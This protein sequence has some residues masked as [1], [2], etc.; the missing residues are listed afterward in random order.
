MHIPAELSFQDFIS[1]Y[2]PVPSGFVS[3]FMS[4]QTDPQNWSIPQ[5]SYILAT[6][7]HE[8]ANTYRC[9]EEQAPH[10]APAPP[11]SSHAE[12]EAFHQAAAEAYF[13]GRYGTPPLS[14]ILG[15]V[16]RGDGYR[17]RGRGFRQ[18]TGRAN[19]RRFAAVLHLGLVSNPGL[20]N[21]PE[22][23][24]QILSVGLARGLFTG[25]R[26]SEYINDEMRDFVNARRVLNGLDC[27]RGIAAD[28]AEFQRC[29]EHAT[30]QPI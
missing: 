25:K 21:N 11:G 14:R 19:Y 7:K 18:I 2:G 23:S 15:N 24:F 6:V 17:F 10:P 22:I 4:I 26:L 28:A 8:T 20:A 9:I 16:G 3:L 29:F 12:V 1:S 27:A 13:N 5:A 30:A